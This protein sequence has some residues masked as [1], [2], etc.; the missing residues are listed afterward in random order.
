MSAV[1]WTACAILHLSTFAQVNSAMSPF[2][3]LDKYEQA[4]GVLQTVAMDVDTIA[5]YT[6]TGSDV[7]P[8][9][10]RTRSELRADQDQID[11]A[12]WTWATIKD[13]YD[14][15]SIDRAS[16][17]QRVWDG[18]K[19]FDY[20]S[21]R[22]ITLSE[23]KIATDRQHRE[24]YVAVGRPDAALAGS[25]PGDH[26]PVIALLRQAKDLRIK[27]AMEAVGGNDCHVLEAMTTS[28]AYSL[29][30]N[31]ERGYNISKA[32]VRKTGDDLYYGEPLS[33]P[34]PDYRKLG[35]SFED[36]FPVPPPTPREECLLV[37]EDVQFAQIDG[38]WVVV[39]GTYTQTEILED[40]RQL[41]SS[42]RISRNNIVLSPDFTSLGAFMPRVPDGTPVSVE[43]QEAVISQVW[44]GGKPVLNINTAVLDTIQEDVTKLLAEREITPK[45]P[46]TVPAAAIEPSAG[47]HVAAGI[48]ESADGGSSQW[49]TYGLVALSAAVIISLF[50][51]SRAGRAN[52]E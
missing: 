7:A 47:I 28:G 12:T 46:A 20:H 32:V 43:G 34:P 30:I 17:G 6:D 51:L 31:P 29:W 16:Y 26:S 33:T 2:D 42:V 14:H 37:L 19:W 36:G 22:K 4:A 21:G 8:L 15:P 40:A 38:I 52:H 25:L 35:I 10:S 9:W 39:G 3:L 13:E 44:K 18:S 11:V 49:M 41:I 24:Q 23:L 48:S 50:V 5:S 45:G 1:D 27:D